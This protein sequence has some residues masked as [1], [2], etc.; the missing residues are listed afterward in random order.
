MWWVRKG[1]EIGN[2]E[3]FRIYAD[4]EADYFVDPE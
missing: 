4:T 3:R 1:N 2:A